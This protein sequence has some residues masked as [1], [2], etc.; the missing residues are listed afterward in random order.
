MK[1][2][3]QVLK[4]NYGKIVSKTKE[5]FELSKET[6][7][8]FNELD[9]ENKFEKEEKLE[10]AVNFYLDETTDMEK[11]LVDYYNEDHAKF[12]ETMKELIEQGQYDDEKINKLL[13]YKSCGVV[14]FAKKANELSDLII[15]TQ[16]LSYEI[17]NEF[18]KDPRVKNITEKTNFAIDTASAIISPYREVAKEQFSVLKTIATNKVVDTK[19]DLE[20]KVSKGFKTLSKK[21]D[22]FSNKLN[23]DKK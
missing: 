14:E 8:K 11:Q 22:D 17:K 4:E 18:S 6:T 1:E 15:E 21:L 10:D 13:V 9:T 7:V 23:N 16:A 19:N 12:L 5:V 3:L 20:E 2:K